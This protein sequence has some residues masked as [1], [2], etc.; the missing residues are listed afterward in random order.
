MTKF[1]SKATSKGAKVQKKDRKS[2]VSTASYHGVKCLLKAVK[3]L[4]VNLIRKQ[5]RKLKEL[6]SDPEEE[7]KKE[8]KK[9]VQKGR[10]ENLE[11]KEQRILR[12]IQSLKVSN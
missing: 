2:K 1:A 8:E 12:Y 9:T 4:R 7:R 10:M 3:N 6:K 11:D 5:L